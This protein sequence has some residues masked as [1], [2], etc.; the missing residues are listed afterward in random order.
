[1]YVQ[2]ITRNLVGHFTYDRSALNIPPL[3]TAQEVVYFLKGAC[4]E[5]LTLLGRGGEPDV[6]LDSFD[7][8]TP[9]VVQEVR[10]AF[11]ASACAPQYHI[12][13]VQCKAS[14]IWF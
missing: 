12:P 11:R 8:V 10:A 13:T 9:C 5:E 7:A 6:W 3:T 14:K 2:G 4:E 1:M